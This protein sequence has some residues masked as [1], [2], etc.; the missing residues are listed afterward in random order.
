V[1]CKGA[2]FGNAATQELI[3]E[4]KLRRVL[5]YIIENLQHHHSKVMAVSNAGFSPPQTGA[6]L[7]LMEEEL[8]YKGG[9][10]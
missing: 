3:S 2:G 4:L 1:I 8:R 9:G 7:P 10:L 5:L 6:T